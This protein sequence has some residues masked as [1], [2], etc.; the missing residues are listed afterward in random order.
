MNGLN[1]LEGLAF[2]VAIAP[3]RKCHYDANAVD[4]VGSTPTRSLPVI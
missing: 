4:A 2:L 1:H 3:A